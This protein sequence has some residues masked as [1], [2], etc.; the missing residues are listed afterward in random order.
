MPGRL[1]I[2]DDILFKEDIFKTFGNFQDDIQVLFKRYNIAPTIN[3]P[4]FTNTKIYTYAHFGLIPSWANDKTNININARSETIFEKSSFREAYKQRR[5]IIPIN[6]YYEWEK[7]TQTKT[8]TP[9][10]IHSSQNNYLA[11]AGVYEYW[12]DN[13]T[14]K[15]ILSCALLTTQPNSKIEA[16]HDR[17]PV[18]LQKNDWIKW[19]NNQSNFET[20]NNLY[21]PYPNEKI[22]II[23]VNDVV[24]SVKNDTIECIQKSKKIKPVQKTLF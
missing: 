4:I 14:G 1:A 7:D 23:E 18:I 19:L 2:Y 9:Y 15:T 20:L 17:M 21:T 24:N 22:D 5:C 11:F 10:M 13:I 12:H 16:I 8:S 3:I 6:G